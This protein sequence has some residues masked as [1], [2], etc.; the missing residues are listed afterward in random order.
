MKPWMKPT[1]DKYNDSKDDLDSDLELVDIDSRMQF[2]LTKRQEKE[3][4]SRVKVAKEQTAIALRKR[5]QQWSYKATI[6]NICGNHRYNTKQTMRRRRRD[7]LM[8]L[9]HSE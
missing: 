9:L 3:L 4:L 6:D 8:A 2:I 5:N 1:F 7:K